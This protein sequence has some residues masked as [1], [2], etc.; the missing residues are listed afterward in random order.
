MAEDE[1]LCLRILAEIERIINSDAFLKD[2]CII[3]LRGMHNDKNK[4]PVLYEEHSLALEGWCIKHI[5]SYAYKE[6]FKNRPLLK[7]NKLP[8]PKMTNLNKLLLGALLIQPDVSTFWNMKRELV[9]FGILDPWRELKFSRLVLSYKHKSNETFT[10]RKW[11][12][13]RLLKSGRITLSNTNE[14]I[15]ISTLFAEEN[16][17]TELA[18]NNAQNNYHAWN[19][20][21]WTM[22]MLLTH[23]DAV[24]EVISCERNFILDWTLRHVSEHAGFHYRQYILKLTKERTFPE[25]TFEHLYDSIRNKLPKGGAIS[26]EEILG[27]SPYSSSKYPNNIR[28]QY[29]NYFCIMLVELLNTLDQYYYFASHESV[30]YHR[31]FVIYT[32]LEIYSEF[33]GLTLTNCKN[34]E[35]NNCGQNIISADLQVHLPTKRFQE[36]GEHCPKLFKSDYASNFN[37]SYLYEILI[38]TERRA[39]EVSSK[40]NPVQQ[41]LG[42]RHG[43]W[44]E[45]IMNFPLEV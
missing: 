22:Q 23:V 44:L 2:F 38:K 15:P 32:L 13:N 4:S 37:N 18:A 6:L 41:E 36:N 25:E 45:F 43:K 26:I 1:S 20:R 28:Y 16:Q 11:C 5:Y 21:I 17:V 8:T 14:G 42:V 9:E 12:I 39:I 3:E 33:H 27:I 35:F 40:S 24:H 10:Y 19:H 29:L 34:F 30:W 7:K 31:R